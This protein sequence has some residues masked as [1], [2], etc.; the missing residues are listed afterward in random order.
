[1]SE[2]NASRG[3]AQEFIISFA[4]D[5]LPAE[6]NDRIHKALHRAV[7]QKSADLDL[8]SRSAI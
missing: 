6:A 8:S 4:G 2:A 1:V 7:L 3:P 5:E